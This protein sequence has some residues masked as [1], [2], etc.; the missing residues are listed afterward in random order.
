MPRSR[1]RRKANRPS[2]ISAA[3]NEI[4]QPRM[5]A[6]G[7][8]GIAVLGNLLNVAG[9][10]DGL[11]RWRDFFREGLLFPYQQLKMALFS[12][13]PVRVPEALHDLVVSCLFILGLQGALWGLTPL[14][15]RA[16]F[17]RA[18]GPSA[19]LY[20][21]MTFGFIPIATGHILDAFTK[22]PYIRMWQTHGFFS[23]ENFAVLGFIQL[24]LVAGLMWHTEA[25]ATKA[26][27]IIIHRQQMRML[28]AY[29]IF[30]A[31]FFALLF[32][33]ADLPRLWR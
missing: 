11:I 26:N 32:L 25:S 17:V 23:F 27:R 18:L 33:A 1:G 22:E 10:T 19:L 14:R 4:Q 12:I 2:P 13:L 28:Q 29:A 24:V 6:I 15:K 8:F 20:A 30:V 9:L 31:S 5:L 16:E 3:A 21:V 7:L